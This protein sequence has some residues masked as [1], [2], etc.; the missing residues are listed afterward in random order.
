[1]EASRS[2]DTAVNR[3]ALLFPADGTS[4]RLVSYI[5]KQRSEGDGSVDFY[6]YLPDLRPWLGSAFP[7][8]DF[9]DFHIDN[10]PSNAWLQSDSPDT[11]G[12]YCLYYTTSSTLPVN[13]AC[14]EIIGVDPPTERLFFR[15]DVFLVKHEG[16]LG[17]GHVYVNTSHDM[18]DLTTK[19][20][21]KMYE[22]EMLEK[23]IESDKAFDR[24]LEKHNLQHPE[25]H[26]AIETGALERFR[27]GQMTGEDIPQ[28]EALRKY[29]IEFPDG[30]IKQL[31]G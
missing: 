12:N 3:V 18:V 5:V 9:A 15:G 20:L 10:K 7:E 6:D 17:M 27:T 25:I 16:S 24:E 28:I 4:V 29:K 13:K 14:K 19:V 1:M 23:K 8:R 26:S 11:W 31:L 2:S 22:N 21:K 30:S